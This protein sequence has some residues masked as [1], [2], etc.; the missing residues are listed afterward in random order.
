MKRLIAMLLTFA[1]LM[2]FMSVS[3]FAAENEPDT[4]IITEDITWENGAIIN[5]ATI[6]GDVT[7]TVKGTVVIAGTIKMASDSIHKVTIKGGT[8]DAK[9]IRGNGFTGQMF[10]VEGSI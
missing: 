5:G 4:G 9:L 1:M 10:Y 6:K 2:S 3:A 8:A 7:I